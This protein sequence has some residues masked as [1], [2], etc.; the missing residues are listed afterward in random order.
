MGEYDQKA[1]YALKSEMETVRSALSNQ[2]FDMERLR[3]SVD[4]LCAA[5]ERSNDLMEWAKATKE[6]KDGSKA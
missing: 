5:V 2:S 3:T 1:M 4:Q 6:S